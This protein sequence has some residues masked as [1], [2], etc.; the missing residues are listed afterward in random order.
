[1]TKEDQIKNILAEAERQILAVLSGNDKTIAEASAS[2]DAT[3]SKIM[4]DAFTARTL[5][6]DKNNIDVTRYGMLDYIPDH[7]IDDLFDSCKN[8]CTAGEFETGSLYK[9]FCNDMTLA[10]G[11]SLNYELEKNID[12]IIFKYKQ[13]HVNDTGFTDGE[14]E[15]EE[16]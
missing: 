4:A 6:L 3:A 7:A 2:I 16:I 12:N 10:M 1:M 13:I 5:L 9:R 14:I 11:T 15:T 8:W